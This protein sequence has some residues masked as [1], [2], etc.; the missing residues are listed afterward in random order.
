MTDTTLTAVR[1][2]AE[3]A[4]TVFTTNRGMPAT[5]TD[6]TTTLTPDGQ[7]SVTA[8]AVGPGA[9]RAL[10]VFTA[11]THIPLTHP[12]DTRQGFDYS[13]SVPGRTACVWRSRGVWV[14]LW[15]PD[16]PSV[17]VASAQP[18]RRRIL[19][20]PGGRL[21]FTRRP[22]INQKETTTR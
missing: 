16:I 13:Y 7:P 11:D 19:G 8:Q 4:W 5:L 6:W 14:E 17:P 22:R 3:E 20:R 15:V 2:Q 18:A 10:R 1:L 21:P 12:G 9:E